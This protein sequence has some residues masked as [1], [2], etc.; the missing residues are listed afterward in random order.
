[1]LYFP[2]HGDFPNRQA[3]VY[4]NVDHVDVGECR[5]FRRLRE[6]RPALRTYVVKGASLLPA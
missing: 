6:T 4:R 1:M 5:H 3:D 2:A